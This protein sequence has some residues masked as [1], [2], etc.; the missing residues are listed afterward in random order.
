MQSRAAE[1]VEKRLSAGPVLEFSRRIL[2]VA[3]SIDFGLALFE[4]PA[5]SIL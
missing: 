3:A 5:L 4:L 2:L 1:A